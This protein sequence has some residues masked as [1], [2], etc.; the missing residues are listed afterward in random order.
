M[1]DLQKQGYKIYGFGPH[2]DKLSLELLIKN[3]IEFIKYPLNRNTLNP[4][5]DLKTIKFIRQKVKEIS[6]DFIVPYTIK[7]VLYSNLAIKSLDVKSISLITGLGFYALPSVNVKE[8][9]AKAIITFL[10]KLGTTKKVIFAFQ[11]TD[12]IDFFK[13]KGILKTNMKWC[14]TPGSGIDLNKFG[15]SEPVTNPISFLFIGRLLKSKGI[16]L[17]LN[18]AEILK[19]KH[20]NIIF[21]IVGMPD[22]LNADSVN[23]DKLKEFHDQNIINYIGEVD[24]V[25]PYFNKSSVFVLPSYYREGVPRTL[26]E[27]LAKGKPII[28]TDH[29]GCRETVVNNENGFLIKPKSENQLTK[30]LEKFINNPDLI[31]KFSPKSRDL[32][33][34]KFDVKIVNEILINQLNSL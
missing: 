24:N 14:I 2:D 17:L 31:T 32:A 12:D 30:A 11:N 23:E 8:K 9:I 3:N 25:V 7:P 21:N 28:T 13:E 4:I 29:V 5:G 22:P 1:K 20:P 19:Q 6:P 33:E 16:A 34:Q 26:L 10:Y 27:A 15:Y 18:S